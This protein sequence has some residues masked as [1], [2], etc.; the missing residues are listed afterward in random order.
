MLC[1]L[2]WSLRGSV[3]GGGRGQTPSWRPGLYTKTHD[4]GELRKALCSQIL[5]LLSFTIITAAKRSPCSYV[6]LGLI[7]L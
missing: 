5:N 3:P 4:P 2:K 6:W 7:F 1:I